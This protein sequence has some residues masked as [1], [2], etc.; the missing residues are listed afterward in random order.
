M[1]V[2]ASPLAGGT[3]AQ[4]DLGGLMAVLLG[5]LLILVFEAAVASNLSTTGQRSLA[6][7]LTVGIAPISLAS[8]ALGT[9]ELARIIRGL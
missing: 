6:R 8:L 4:G 3:A 1:T 2:F 7:A 9:I 5:T